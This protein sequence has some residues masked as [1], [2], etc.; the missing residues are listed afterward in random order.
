MTTMMT[1]KYDCEER[2]KLFYKRFDVL[3][4]KENTTALLGQRWDVSNPNP[5]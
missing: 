2:M 5:E 1:N 3:D 4:G